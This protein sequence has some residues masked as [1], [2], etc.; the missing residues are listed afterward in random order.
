M[1]AIFVSDKIRWKLKLNVTKFH[2]TDVLWIM[3]FFGFQFKPEGAK[4][5]VLW[6]RNFIMHW[7]MGSIKIHVQRFSFSRLLFFMFATPKWFFPRR[8]DL[9]QKQSERQFFYDRA[10]FLA[11]IFGAFL[12]VSVPALLGCR[13]LILT[14]ISATRTPCSSAATNAWWLRQPGSWSALDLSLY[15]YSSWV[16]IPS[17]LK[18]VKKTDSNYKL[19]PRLMY[20]FTTFIL[21][22]AKQINCSKF[23]YIF[24]LQLFSILSYV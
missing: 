8:F 24:F 10:W 5:L 1:E 9:H 20:D 18:C 14:N 7:I 12:C 22:A 17:G 15:R 21:H 2:F 16:A 19:Q 6:S 3:D 4:S 13:M 23:K 11:P